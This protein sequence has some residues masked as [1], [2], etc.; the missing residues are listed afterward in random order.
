MLAAVL[1]FEYGAVQ[2][3]IS[4]FSPAFSAIADAR[5]EYAGG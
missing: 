1:P 3:E 5:E 4:T 2:S